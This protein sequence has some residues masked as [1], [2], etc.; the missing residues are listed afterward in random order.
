MGQ[1]LEKLIAQIL[2]YNMPAMS[3]LVGDYPDIPNQLL[4]VK[5]QQQQTVDLGKY[6]PQFSTK[7]EKY[8]PFD[9]S[10]VRY[11][12]ALTNPHTFVIEG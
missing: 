8:Q 9:T 11:I 6:S 5:V 12:I 7:L 1:E 2:E 4:E 10:Q 3:S